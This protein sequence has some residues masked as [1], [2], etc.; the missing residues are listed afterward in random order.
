MKKRIL[1]VGIVVEY[2]PFHNGHLYQINKIKKIFGEKIFLVIIV[3]GDFV[4]RG[5]MSFLNKWEK[6]QAALKSGIDLIVELPLYYSIQNAEIF[7]KISTKTLDYL[8][9]DIQ[10]FG[11]EEENIEKLKKVIEIQ[12][13]QNYKNKLMEYMKLGNSYTSSQRLALE[14]Y[15]LQDVVKS[16]N[17]LAIEY[18]REIKKEKLKINPYVI[19]R[20]ISEYNEKKVKKSSKNFASALFIRSKIEFE[21]QNIDYDE[22]GKYVPNEVIKIIK[23]KVGKKRDEKKIKEK[24]FE[25]FKYK[26]LTEEKEKIL[27]I[28]DISE[29]IYRRLTNVVKKSQNF[30]EFTKNVKSRNFSNKRID[31][32]IFN[33]LLNIK[34]SIMNYEIDYV[35]VLGFNH[36][37]RLLLKDL[38]EKKVFVNW[39][40]IEKFSKT[41]NNKILKE[42]VKIEKNGFY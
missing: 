27:Q 13:S 11:A 38:K 41:E 42:K 15:G 28:Y 29:E 9:I 37:G 21:G 23:E 22:I 25:I 19:K 33:V 16:N 30:F 8:N 1:K 5:E 35:R 18:M 32:I 26:I 7:C 31:R 20:E 17:I 36:T 6:T 12:E 39:K 4:Q 40:D 34:E 10:V 14:E 2:N 24:I 3:S